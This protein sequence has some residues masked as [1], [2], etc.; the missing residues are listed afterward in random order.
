MLATLIPLLTRFSVISGGPGTGK[1]T[2]AAKVLALL[3][4]TSNNQKLKITLASPT[5][6]A[7]AGL[8][9]S[10][11]KAR[12]TL[13][14]GDA[15]KDQIPDET[16]TI[17]RLLGSI[18]GSPY[19]RYDGDN[20]L[21]VDILMIDEA[22]MI[23][24]A[25]M[26]KLMQALP[27]TAR[28]ILM[29]DKDQLAS[30]ESGSVLGDICNRDSPPGFSIGLRD[31]IREAIG[32]DLIPDTIAHSNDMGLGDCIVSL[33][34]SYRF[35]NTIGIGGLSRSVNQGNA[36]AAIDQLRDPSDTQVDW[37]KSKSVRTFHRKM[38]EQIIAGFS[39]YLKAEDPHDALVLL[40]RFRILCGVRK[41]PY[42]I[43]MINRLAEEALRREGLIQSD[44][45]WYRGRPVLITRN[46]YDLRLF[47][48]DTGVCWGHGNRENGDLH[49]FFPDAFE[50][51]RQISIHR[52][53]EHETAYAMTVHKSQGA[54]FEEV[55][56]VFP[57]RDMPLLTRE[58]VYTGM[59]RAREHV[60]F[61]CAED[62]LRRAVSRKI[63][64]TS[65]LRDG[66]W[67][68]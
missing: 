16:F 45:P 64:R 49:A 41:G 12:E 62:L 54:E 9:E 24:L 30:V 58:W 22:S 4:E 28:L 52:L 53:P 20:P 11:Q 2:L 26:S 36:G 18:S 21:P 42:G 55:H 47:N 46:D 57:D 56:L 38:S 23:D 66:L 67:G 33:D 44:G 31:R 8:R 35:S 13:A 10:I 5:G 61:W 68:A 17:H 65:G 50:K 1:T 48:G 7:A 29:G 60:T 59:T 40:S 19:F 32:R 63:S 34:R 6:K 37:E 27:S 15:V 14:C 25:L 3:I 39:D 43:E 51:L